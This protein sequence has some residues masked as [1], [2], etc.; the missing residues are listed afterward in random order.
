VA[1]VL[2]LGFG[3]SRFCYAAPKGRGMKPEKL[4]GLRVATSYPSIVEADLAKRGV[5]AKIVKL[6]GAVEISIQLGVADAIA[7][8]VDSGRTLEEAGLE[9]IADPVMFSEA[10]LIAAHGKENLPG[11]Q[12]LVRRMQGILVAREYC[13]LEYVAPKARLEDACAIT[14]GVKSPTLSPLHDPEWMAVAAMVKRKELNKVIDRLADL[15]AKGIIA[16]DINTCRL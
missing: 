15:G 3:R 5:T 8:V 16:H 1:P 2:T 13:L 11:L 12:M 7:D 4:G 6:D 9:I 14:P 10:V